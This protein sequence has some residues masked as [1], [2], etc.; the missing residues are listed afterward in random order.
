MSLPA[1]WVDRIFEKLSVAYGHDFLRRW[2]GMDIALVKADWAHEL[3]GYA[4]MPYAIR[5]AMENLPM[6]KPPTARSF[7]SL[8]NAV[9]VAVN[10]GLPA[11]SEKPPP[12]VAARLASVG[13][14]VGDPKAWARRL[15]DIELN[16][17][18]ELPNG[19]MMTLAQR[20]SW[21]QALC[22]EQT[23]EAA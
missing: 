21:R 23:T 12:A 2:E 11:P 5:Y 22:D 3:A 19:R 7:R 6:D 8:C 14:V 10:L 4:A 20:D 1:A 17:G 15:R 16:R 9:P 13:N 18:G